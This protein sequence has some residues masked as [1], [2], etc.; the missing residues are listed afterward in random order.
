MPTLAVPLLST[1][2]SWKMTNSSGEATCLP[3]S[4]ATAGSAAN[5]F[6]A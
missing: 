4:M 5:V 6:A 2:W 1:R 3:P